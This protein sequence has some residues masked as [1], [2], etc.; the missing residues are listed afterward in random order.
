MIPRLLICLLALGGALHAQ[1][2]N[3]YKSPYSVNFSFKDEELIGDLI[4]GPRGDW[5]DQADVPFREWYNP[6]NQGRWRH[7]GPSAKHFNPPAGLATKSPEWSRERVI[8]TGLRFVG[9]TYLHHHNPDWEPPSDWPTA[10]EPK[11]PVGT[12]LERNNFLALGYKPARALH[13]PH[14]GA[15]RIGRD[16][17]VMQNAVVR[18]SVHYV[19]TEDELDRFATLVH[20]ICGR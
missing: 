7:Y 20:Q 16:C 10:P 9:Y 12:G 13:P 6:S 8:A 11:T 17:I 4:K 2:Q 3:A 18:A 1:A 19:T 5:K 14:G 15:I